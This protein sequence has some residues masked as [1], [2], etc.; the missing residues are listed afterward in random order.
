[1]HAPT[2]G[3]SF[4]PKDSFYEELKRVLCQIPKY[5]MKIVL[6]VFNEKVGKEVVFKPVIR[7]ESLH[8][9]DIGNGARAV[10]FVMSES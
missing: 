2:E 7:N 5:H 3:K 8:D 1:V 10:K 4:D 9:I 6:G